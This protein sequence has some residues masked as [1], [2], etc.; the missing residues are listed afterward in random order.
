M[1]HPQACTKLQVIVVGAGL[2]GLAAALSISLS[3][4]QVTVL[5]SAPE[6]LEVGYTTTIDALTSNC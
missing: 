6:L 1:A 5:E 2:A 3:G 4:H